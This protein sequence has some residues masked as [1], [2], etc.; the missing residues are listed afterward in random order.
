MNIFFLILIAY[1]QAASMMTIDDSKDR[2]SGEFRVVEVQRDLKIPCGVP[3]FKERSAKAPGCVLVIERRG[4]EIKGEKSIQ[5][6]RYYNGDE[7][8]SYAKGSVLTLSIINICEGVGLVTGCDLKEPP[9]SKR[10]WACSLKSWS[11]S[12]V[13]QREE[14]PKDFRQGVLTDEEYKKIEDRI[15]NPK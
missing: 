10:M 9:H 15:K 1:T 6:Y 8:C 3:Q 4:K 12:G 7:T 11:K 13:D 5:K 14:F 2:I